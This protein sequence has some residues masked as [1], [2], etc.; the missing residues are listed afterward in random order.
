[1]RRVVILASALALGAGALASTASAAP[2]MMSGS[3][4]SGKS[5][6]VV[7]LAQYKRKY[8]KRYRNR[9][10]RF[11][12]GSRH[13]RAPGGWRRYKQRPSG[14]STRGCIVVGPLWYCP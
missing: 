2:S 10:H 11:K 12:P 6:S 8:K 9:K 13:S 3:G 4:I 7:E 1:M 14:W 5:G